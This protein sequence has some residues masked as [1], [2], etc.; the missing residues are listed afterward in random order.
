MMHAAEPE[1]DSHSAPVQPSR[2][3][4]V[5]ASCEGRLRDGGL[6][7]HSAAKCGVDALLEL[8]SKRA[9]YLRIFVYEKCSGSK[10]ALRPNSS[11]TWIIT[12]P[13]VGREQHTF[14]HHVLTH[15]DDLAP[16]TLFTPSDICGIERNHTL[17]PRRKQFVTDLLALPELPSAGITCVGLPQRLPRSSVGLAHRGS[18][19]LPQLPRPSAPPLPLHEVGVLPLEAYRSFTMDR[20]QGRPLARASPRPLRAWSELHLGG[21]FDASGPTCWTGAFLARRESIR[22]RPRRTYAHLLAEINH[23]SEPEAIHYLERLAAS[24]YGRGSENSSATVTPPLLW[25]GKL[26]FVY[27]KDRLRGH[28]RRRDRMR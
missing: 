4:V 18:K 27:P 28:R 10:P 21:S 20:Y 26:G 1:A 25:A 9:E 12:L 6:Y 2:L 5:V 7:H 23:D 3:D 14:L 24:V 8:L 11:S 19:V 13:N 15:Y 17:P 16:H 22:A